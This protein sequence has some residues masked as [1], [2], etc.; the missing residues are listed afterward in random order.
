MAR[1]RSQSEHLD[2]HFR[3]WPF[4]PTGISVR[5]VAGADKRDVIQMRIDLGI[6]QLE[7]TGRPD[8]SWPHGFE[9]YHDYLIHEALNSGDD[10]VL[11]EEQSAEADREFVQYYHRRVC[12]LALGN[13]AKAVE[14]ADHTLGLMDFCRDHSADEQ[15][16]IT[17]EQ[18][19]PFVLFHRTQAAAMAALERNGAE[20]AIQEISDGLDKMRSVFE[21]YDAL[22]QYDDDELVA[23]LVETRETLRQKHDVGK[24]LQEQLAEAIASEQYEVAARIRDELNRRNPGRR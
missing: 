18:Y 3:K 2:D 20:D 16:T 22:D 9:T 6:L 19:R 13:F 7:T 21:R 12:W 4:D 8:G 1:R 23:R 14:D 11:N 10:F 17:H 15:W 5:L 24:T